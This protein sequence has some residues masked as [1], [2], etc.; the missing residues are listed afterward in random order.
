M[1]RETARACAELGTTA[2]PG[3]HVRVTSASPGWLRHEDG[4]TTIDAEYV[5][6]GFA[7]VHAI[8]RAGC[9]ALVDTGAKA[10][11]P[12]VLQVL[13]QQ[14]LARSAV[15]F[16]FLTHVHL[17]HAGGAGALVRDLPNARVVVHPRG[18]AHLI[19][20][21]RLQAATA[22]VYGQAAFERLYGELVPIDEARVQ[23]TSDGQ[24]LQLG[25]SE[26]VVLHTPG[27]AL[28]HQVL[29][30]AEAGIAFTGDTFGLSYR[31]LDTDKGAFVVPTTS[32]TQFDPEQ[33][34]ASI[35][36]IRAL[37]LKAVYLTHYGRMTDVARLAT[38]LTEQVSAFV[39]MARQHA[40]SH[41]P[42]AKIHAALRAY[43][44]ARAKR[45]G[46]LEPLAMVE[47]ILG[48]DIELNAQGLVA[49]L[50]RVNNA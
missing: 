18:A 15:E 22:Q 8:E 43:L 48:P 5:R 46:I 17:D 19:S 33:L 11:V 29:V 50:K 25:T 30:D 1:T 34:L 31:E 2:D 38:D 24:R 35:E 40:N 47:C 41:D 28:H 20:P 16:V 13:E 39:A 14:G 10:A 7:C 42:Q 21:A 26:F 49:W 37:Q 45:H 27:H 9:V 3:Y 12:L 4:V 36:R 23:Q 44:A 32:P 6:P